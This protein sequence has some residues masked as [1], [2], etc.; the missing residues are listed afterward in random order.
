[1][2]GILPLWK[3]KGLTSHDCVARVRR[4]YKTKKAGHTGTLDPEAEGVLPI[5]IGQA[6]KVVP[7][8]TETRKVYIAE[9]ALGA[10]TE[11]EDGQGRV[12][13]KTV[14]PEVIPV[15]RINEAL[16]RLRGTIWQTPPMYS[17]VKVNG[18]KLYEYARAGETVERPARQVT[19]H[20]LEL[21]SDEMEQ[22]D[23]LQYFKLLIECSKGTYI[24]TLCVDV[25]RAL[26]WPAHMAQLVRTETGGFTQP[27]CYT[28][29]QVEQAASEDKQADL[30]VPLRK[31]L[32]HLDVLQVSLEW[33]E[34]VRH[35]Q[36]FML[37]NNK[38]LT[39]PF[40]VQYEEEVLAVYTIH[41]TEHNVAKP[42]KVFLH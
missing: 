8:L 18:R 28:F 14:L 11:T 4:L 25:G 38:P 2:N 31:G 34:K 27:D 33:R 39:D 1:M 35:G 17:A 13:E 6:T 40:R 22:K 16:D 21:L 10:A 26:G 24:R 3:P 19:I 9:A 30:L 5:C 29:D 12:V 15:V 20:R 7:F 37:G 23:G 41:P 42:L 32:E 36:K